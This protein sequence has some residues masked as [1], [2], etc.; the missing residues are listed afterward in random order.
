VLG[1]A[2]R[3]NLRHGRIDF[4]DMIWLPVVNNLPGWS[5]IDL[6]LVDEGPRFQPLPAGVGL[7]A[8]KRII[9][10][11]DERQAI[12]GFAGADVDSIDRMEGC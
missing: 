11:G 5:S 8:G 9:L 4:N 7:K 2:G 10:V 6:L 12:Y 3:W 1:E